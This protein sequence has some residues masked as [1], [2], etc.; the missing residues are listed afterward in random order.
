MG[1]LTPPLSGD[2]LSIIG[3]LPPDRAIGS[4]WRR[5]VA[6]VVDGIIVG[7]AGSVVAIPFAE[8]LRWYL[9]S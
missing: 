8:F 4:L 5:I 7:V 9:V 6:F 3:T 1:I 2:V